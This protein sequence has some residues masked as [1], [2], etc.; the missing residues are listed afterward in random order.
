[1]LIKKVDIAGPRSSL[2]ELEIGICFSITA[3]TWLIWLVR[4]T[5]MLAE[6]VEW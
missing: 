6:I 1:V 3:D 4:M 2:I 5:K